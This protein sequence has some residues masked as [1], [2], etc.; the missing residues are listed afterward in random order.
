MMPAKC[1]KR[2]VISASATVTL[3]FEV[4]AKVP[5]AGSVTPRRSSVPRKNGNRPMRLL[6][7][8]KRNG[9]RI[10]GNQVAAALPFRPAPN[11]L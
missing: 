7:R 1:V 5:S 3:I 6:I 4:A 2:K 8:M 10:D 9:V 11:R